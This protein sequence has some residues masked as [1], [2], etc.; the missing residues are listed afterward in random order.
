MGRMKITL[1]GSHFFETVIRETRRLNIHIY[2]CNKKKGVITCESNHDFVDWLTEHGIIVNEIPDPEKMTWHFYP[3]EFR[4]TSASLLSKGGAHD[5]EKE[6]GLPYNSLADGYELTLEE[7][8]FIE[9]CGYKLEILPPP[10][11]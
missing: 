4:L 6:L 8:N 11:N 5:L 3:A 9:S 1:K 7:K 10:K 2:V